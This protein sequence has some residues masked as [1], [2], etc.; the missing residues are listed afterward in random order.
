MIARLSIGSIGSR[1]L[2][3]VIGWVGILGRCYGYP[4][5]TGGC[6][7]GSYR[8]PPWP[9]GKAVS[10]ASET[11]RRS[12]VNNRTF[13]EGQSPPL[14]PMSHHR[15]AVRVFD[16]EPIPRRPGPVGSGQALRHDPFQ[17]HRARLPEHELA[18]GIRVLA[19][20][21]AGRNA[22]QQPRQGA[23]CARRA[24]AGGSP[25]RRRPAGW[26]RPPCRGDAAHRIR[27]HHPRR[28][29]RPRR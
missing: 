5:R 18:G 1:E 4:E 7:S 21:D 6:L 22:S 15:R 13:G 26:P 20:G 17:A 2:G 28:T 27:R 29:P 25:P 23:S 19:E 11:S 3:R 14:R 9:T 10:G 24:R 16:L 12:A 8:P